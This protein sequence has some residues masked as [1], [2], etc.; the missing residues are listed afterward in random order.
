MKN[1]DLV[2]NKEFYIQWIG[3]IKAIFIST[4]GA[5]AFVVFYCYQNDKIDIYLIIMIVTML[6]VVSS[7][8]AI[9]K[10]LILKLG[11]KGE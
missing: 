9:L 10:N 3:V 1:N 5:L 4:I 8:F 11:S 2:L 7:L 6:V